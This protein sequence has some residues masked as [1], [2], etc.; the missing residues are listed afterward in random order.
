MAFL[1]QYTPVSDLDRDAITAFIEKRYKVTP[2]TPIFASESTNAP[3]DAQSF[4]RWYESGC[5]AFKIAKF[6]GS[7]IM[8]GQCSLTSATII[9][10]LTGDTIVLGSTPVDPE[11]L[12][13]ASAQEEEGFLEAMYRACLQPDPTTFTLKLKYIPAPNDKVLFH[14][15]DF[16]VN[17]VAIIRRVMPATGGVELCCYFIYPTRTEKGKLGC[18]MRESDVADLQHYVFEPLLEPDSPYRF[19]SEDGISAYRRLKRE[20]EKEGKTWKDK[21]SRVEPLGARL[22]NGRTYYYISDKLKVVAAVEKGTPT[23]QFRYSCGNYFTD[24][25]AANIVLGKIN[26]LI[27]DYLALPGWPK[28]EGLE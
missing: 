22:E 11:L 28:I 23:G 1:S 19:S 27:R 26:D 13:E 16:A 24:L 21:Y 18:T 25:E 9:G 7:T 8:V 14:S 5:M 6:G 15:L 2:A 17:G 20:L 12:K 10:T 3:L 4:L